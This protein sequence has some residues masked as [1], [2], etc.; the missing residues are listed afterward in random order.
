MTKLYTQDAYCVSVCS[1]NYYVYLNSTST[2]NPKQCL[3]SC[4]LGSY[5]LTSNVSCMPCKSPCLTCLNEQFCLSCVDGYY[6]T[7]DNYCNATCPYKYYG[8]TETKTC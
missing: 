1:N 3:S 4:P 6:L 7:K 5:T 8:K 2:T